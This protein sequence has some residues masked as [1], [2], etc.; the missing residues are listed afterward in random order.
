M[1][2]ENFITLTASFVL[3]GSVSGDIEKLRKIRTNEILNRSEGQNDYNKYETNVD[4]ESVQV[5]GLGY[6]ARF[7]NE[8]AFVCE[9]VCPAGCENG[10][11]IAPGIC[12]CAAGYE[13]R[14]IAEKT[15]CVPLHL[16]N[17][18]RITDAHALTKR[19]AEA[20]DNLITCKTSK[21]KCWKADSTDMC[22][23]LCETETYQCLDQKFSDCI[24]SNKSM[25]Y[26][27]DSA[28]WKVYSC[29]DDANAA[30]IRRARWFITIGCIFIGIMLIPIVYLCVRIYQTR[31]ETGAHDIPIS[32]L[33][34]F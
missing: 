2:L 22:N 6:T 32:L 25:V 30:Y 31:H 14:S 15:E 20:S 4:G 3:F 27:K 11:C 21:C 23:Y 29:V 12:R 5:C 9:P 26:K 33:M 10:T 1:R 13:L 34:K 17:D 28:N 19:N 24:E 8:T 18:A 7:C 16:N